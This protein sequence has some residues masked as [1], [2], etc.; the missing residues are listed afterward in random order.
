MK[1][2]GQ[3]IFV[4]APDQRVPLPNPDHRPVGWTLIVEAVEYDCILVPEDDPRC[5]WPLAVGHRA[6]VN[7][8]RGSERRP[9]SRCLRV[10]IEATHGRPGTLH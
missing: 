8:V 1:Q 7:V 9:P 5:E 10:R 4:H 2:R 6:I 3:H